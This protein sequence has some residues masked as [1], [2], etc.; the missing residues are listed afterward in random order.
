MDVATNGNSSL[1]PVKSSEIKNA[2]H[3]TIQ[4]N[5][6][7]CWRLFIYLSLGGIISILLIKN[8]WEK[9]NQQMILISGNDYI[10]KDKILNSIDIELPLITINPKY[11]ESVL[12]Q[13]LPIKAVKIN[14][15]ILPPGIHIEILERIPVAYAT[16]NSFGRKEKG[17]IDYDGYWI[18]SFASNNINF[19]KDKA[20]IIDGWVE[21]HQ[22]SIAHIFRERYTL[23]S[24][25]QEIIISPNGEISLSTKDFK[26]IHLGSNQYLLKEQINLLPYLI[27]SLP[28][29][30]KNSKEITI[31]IKDPTR[32]K[33][34]TK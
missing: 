17:M 4:S 2:N 19:K 7:N 18:P 27:D 6:I 3:R 28:E 8:G 15:S 21:S 1:R 33:L 23:G 10:S 12:L 9:V 13:D 32:P 11:F 16:R 22:K 25:L 24:P 14:R 26:L 29:E 20:V 5:L 31:D 30:I 34:L